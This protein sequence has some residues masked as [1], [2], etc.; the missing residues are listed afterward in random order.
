MSSI[1]DLSVE[2]VHVY[3]PHLDERRAEL[4]ACAAK[5][6]GMPIVE[7]YEQVGLTVSTVIMLDDYFAPAGTDIARHGRLL[8][9]ACEAVDV[10]VDHLA[11]EADCAESV[12]L[13]RAHL[14]PEPWH[15]DSSSNPSTRAV[16]S[17]WLEN[18][19]PTRIE[20]VR[21]EVV[22][23]LSSISNDREVELQVRAPR[24]PRGRHAIHL[25]VELS[26]ELAGSSARLW[27]CPTL[28]AWWQLIRLGMLS[29][30][31]CGKPVAPPRTQ[32]RPDAPPLPARRTLTLLE[33]RF[34][35]VEHAVRVILERVSLPGVWRRRLREGE[36]L[37]DSH[38]H[39]KRI[40]YMFVPGEF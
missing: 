22:G 36:Q 16:G 23:A 24:Q 33:P 9:E 10:R 28:S 30:E 15:D 21:S 20:R 5:Q 26:S 3:L 27:A 39:L 6:W 17:E 18:G 2:F 31:E 7:A 32:S 8:R 35:E 14:S 19:D 4:A 37:V 12:A 29:D 25:D 13:M 40:A 34:L 11:H 38:E 1:S